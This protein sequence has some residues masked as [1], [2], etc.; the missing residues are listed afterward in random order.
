MTS[1]FIWGVQPWF[2]W[3]N[4]FSDFQ[5]IIRAEGILQRGV[6]LT[7]FTYQT[8]LPEE[9]YI[10]GLVAGILLVGA[11]FSSRTDPISKLAAFGCGCILATPYA[12]NYDLAFLQVA[13]VP[14]LLDRD[15]DIVG[16]VGAGM[17][18]STVLAPIGVVLMATSIFI[19]F[20]HTNRAISVTNPMISF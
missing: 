1:L 13:A 18:F 16:W 20:Y 6:T 2:D 14:M 11:I 8:N 9:I 17:V 3:L 5:Q 4:S 7:A 10:V 15:R 19:K 12:M